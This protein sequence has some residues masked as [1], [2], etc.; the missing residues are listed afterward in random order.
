[1]YRVGVSVL[2]ASLIACGA[3]SEASAAVVTFDDATGNSIA[4][5]GTIFDPG[6]S[7]SDQ[8]LTFKNNGQNAMTVFNDPT[9]GSG[10]G[11]GTNANIFSFNAN[12]V[13]TITLTAGG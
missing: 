2:F 10:T 6:Q 11:N 8:G 1:M 9:F 5:A 7:F 12:D 13:E 4:S 3:A